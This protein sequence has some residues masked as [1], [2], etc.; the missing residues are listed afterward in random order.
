[1]CQKHQFKLIKIHGF[2]HT[3]CSLLF[4]AGLSIQEVQNRLGHGDIKIIMAI[5][6]HVTENSQMISIFSINIFKTYSTQNKRG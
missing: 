1:M 6:A 4:E 3:R 2:S 5:Y